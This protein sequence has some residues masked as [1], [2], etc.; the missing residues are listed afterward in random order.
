MERYV[1]IHGHFYQ[2]PRE[3][4][5]LEQIEIQD[6]AYPYHDWNERVA[7]ECYTPN[8]ESRILDGEGYITRIVNNYSRMSFNFGPTLLSWMERNVPATYQAI[9]RA[10]RSSMERF[11]GH[12]SAMAQAYNHMILPLATR[13]DK[14]T[15]VRWGIADFEH[16]FCRRPEGMWL[17]E[18]A[19]DI[20]TLDVLAEEGI[21][22][23]V[24]APRQAA[25]VRPAGAADWI[26]VSGERIDPR[27]AYTQRLPS[28]R[29]IAIF[30]YDGP[31]ARAV[32]FERILSSGEGFAGRL[33]GA[34]RNDE[35][36]QLVNIAVDGETFG[37]HHRFG[38]MALAYALHHIQTNGLA[39]ITDY[40]EYLAMFP[41][42]HEVEIVENS[43]WS[44]VHGVERWR[45]DCGCNTGSGE[46]W[47]Q[48]WRGPLREA[49]DWLRDAT[50]PAYE[51][52]ARRFVLDPWRTRDDYISVVLDRSRE[53]VDSFLQSH[54]SM[55]L[56]EEERITLLKL[57]EMERHT[58]LMYTSCGWFFDELS[59]I[60]T[61]QVMQYAGRVVQLAREV[62]GDS[63]ETAFLERLALAKSNLSEHGDGRRIY[64]RFVKPAKVELS[65]VAAHFAVSSVF[66]TYEKDI[67][68][69][70]YP[71]SVQDFR[72]REMGRA[73]LALGKARLS[74]ELTNEAGLF[75]FGVLYFGEHNLNAGVR[76][77]LDEERYQAMV[78]DLSRVYETADFP[79][80]VRCL[81]RH[82]GSS[83]YSLKSL[84]RDEQRTVMGYILEGTLSEIE[85]VFRQLYEHQ[86]P[87]MRF[88]TEMGNPLPKAFKDAAEF[89]LNTDLRRALSAD[90]LDVERI[91]NLVSNARIWD[92]ELD[93]EGH[94]YLLQQTLARMMRQV[95][96][97]PDDEAPLQ[98][99]IAAVAL[100]Q[101]LPFPLDLGQ[102]QTL[103]YRML[104]VVRKERALR[105]RLGDGAATT[106]LEQFDTLG[107]RLRV[108]TE[109]R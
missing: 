40:G 105:A 60:E 2:P 69:F 44:C 43:S 93:G 32:A 4:A 67:K 88:L 8:A 55:A 46:G 74:S 13:R 106:W 47:H 90:D 51:D 29:S 82:F 23:T 5:W 62:C 33:M 86:Y 66:D 61:V 70:C 18:T 49:L 73:R 16:R 50:A 3:N 56:R 34:F 76:D 100:S 97:G 14:V 17:P 12:G 30:F 98:R 58:M 54:T 57:L 92:S 48:G 35:R 101:R 109:P 45:S 38:D 108:R 84:F 63:L 37:H 77:Y 96:D 87:P 78:D 104:P 89:I 9:L 41:P 36:P 22:F 31:I 75:T 24:L 80:V 19:V 81:D 91:E 102:V 52:E 79:E 59:R 25:R 72:M 71:I 10:D 107:A 7:A 20:E 83:T 1:C 85:Q 103:Y 15:Q 99:L 21:A 64:E 26:D 11:S 28:G 65:T 68:L 27:M 95:F 53:N 94:G 39:R 6:S 42:T